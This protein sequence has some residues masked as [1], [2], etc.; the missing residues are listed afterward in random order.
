MRSQ[1]QAQGYSIM[2]QYPQFNRLVVSGGNIAAAYTASTDTT[3][4]SPE[5]VAAATTSQLSGMAGVGK[6]EAGGMRHLFP[7]PEGFAIIAPPSISPP[8]DQTGGDST[9]AGEE[10]AV[11]SETDSKLGPDVELGRTTEGT[12]YGIKMVQADDPAMIQISQKF[13]H[14]VLF[15]VIDTGLDRTNKEFSNKSE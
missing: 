5:V 12:P 1:L 13:K 11:C 8:A 9:D 7:Q 15:C 14:K 4:A 2:R 6:V 10:N 3:S